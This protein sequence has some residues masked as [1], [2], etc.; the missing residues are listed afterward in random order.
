[1]HPHVRL[2]LLSPHWISGL[3]TPQ[4]ESTSL[5]KIRL[6]EMKHVF[7]ISYYKMYISILTGQFTIKTEPNPTQIGSIKTGRQKVVSIMKIERLL[8]L[9]FCQYL[10]S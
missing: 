2:A 10:L 5:I 1:M 6:V 8:F 4:L 3:R 7:F 9:F